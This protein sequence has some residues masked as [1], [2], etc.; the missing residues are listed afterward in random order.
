MECAARPA[1]PFSPGPFISELVA[2]SSEDDEVCITSKSFPNVASSVHERASLPL[3]VHEALSLVGSLAGYLS[4]VWPLI[5]R[6]SDALW[7]RRMAPTA[8]T[9]G[10]GFL[11]A[12]LTAW[13]G[14]LT[15]MAVCDRLASLL[16]FAQQMLLARSVGLERVVQ[17]SRCPVAHSSIEVTEMSSQHPTTTS[18]RRVGSSNKK[19]TRELIGAV[20]LDDLH[21]R[22][23]EDEAA[24]VDAQDGHRND[25]GHAMSSKRVAT[26][27]SSAGESGTATRLTIPLAGRKRP[28]MARLIKQVPNAHVA[29]GG[30]PSMLKTL[31]KALATAGME[32]VVRLT[33]SM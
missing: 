2:T 18:T 9:G 7:A 30:P 21:S 32:P 33:H 6:D 1:Q 14:A 11:L 22:V 26:G 10:G 20:S 5:W 13:V 23:V 25:I 28:D 31:D 19:P 15:L 16:K 29:A 17:A 4:I 3:P 24:A 27:E 12:T 8:T